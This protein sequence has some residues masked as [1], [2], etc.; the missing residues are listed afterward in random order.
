MERKENVQIVKSKKILFYSRTDRD[1]LLP[2]PT[3]ASKVLPKWFKDMPKYRNGD[4][5]FIKRNGEHHN[6]TIK[7][8]MPFV[9]SLTGGYLFLLSSDVF[10]TQTVHGPE[11]GWQEST[12]WSPSNI[13]IIYSDQSTFIPGMP[14]A[15]GFDFP[16]FTWQIGWG[17]TTPRGYSTLFSHP[18]NRTELPFFTFTAIVDTDKHGGNT[19][20]NFGVK[21]G[22]EGVIE[23]GTPIVQVFPFKRDSWKSETPEDPSSYRDRDYKHR[24]WRDLKLRH[25]YRDDIW[26]TKRYR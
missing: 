3:V 11:F 15:P 16:N 2:P 17:I 22:F 12:P 23:K 9:D 6:L 10:V 21:T 5:N 26:V 24:V 18:F 8:C 4:K 19:N 7:N 14:T 25:W 20:I 13:P 1:S